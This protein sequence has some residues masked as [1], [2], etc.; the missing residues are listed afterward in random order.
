M[1]HVRANNRQT[2]A[3]SI[4]AMLVAIALGMGLA[5]RVVRPVMRLSA[6]AKAIGAGDWTAT[7][8]VDRDDEVG[9]LSRSFNVMT[10]RIRQLIDNLKAEVAMR[11]R[12]EAG[13]TSALAQAQDEQEKT[14]AILASVGDGI[15]IQS[16][17]YRVLYQNQTHKDFIGDHA[18]EFCYAGYEKRDS[19]C[20]GC[21]VAI[22]FQDG[23]IHRAE[24]VVAFPEGNRYFEITASPLRDST[25][26]IIAGIELVR[27]VTERARANEAIAAEK[28]R[29]AVTLRSIGDAV[30]V[31]DLSGNVTLVNRLAETIT[32]WNAAEAVGRPLAD[33]FTIVDKRTREVLEN[34]VNEVFRSGQLV[35]LR[36]GTALVRRDGSEV[37]IEDSAAPI[38]DA[39][40]RIIGVV[41]VFRDI[42]DKKR[43]EEE[44]LKS[45]KLESLGILAGGLAHDFNNLL[46]AI[47]GNISIAKIHL[48]PEHKIYSRLEDAE[49]AA[50]RA[51]D[52]T[53]RLLTFSKGGHPGQEDRIHRRDHQ[54]VGRFHPLG[55]QRQGG[56]RPSRDLLA[57]GRRFRPDEPGLHQ[58]LGQR[59][60]GDAERRDPRGAHRE[61]HPGGAGS[62]AAPRGRVRENHGE[63]Q[64]Q[65][66]SRGL[67]AEDLRPLFHDKTAGQR[68]WPLDRVLGRDQARGSHPGHLEAG[69]G[70]GI[71]HLPAGVA[72]RSARTRGRGRGP[73]PRQG[74]GS[75]DGRRGDDQGD[76][77]PDTPGTG[78]RGRM[79]ERRGGGD[80]KISRPPAPPGNRSTSS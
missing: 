42:T 4:L 2:V 80:R 56:V 40:S 35:T 24:R 46:T 74:A 28:E 52:L 75:R 9:E 30:I 58:P 45:E 25:G 14:K 15:S 39:K 49:N 10:S 64:R 26:A 17:D 72:G 19:L 78:V 7:A 62:R 6:T 47:M 13:L 5:N 69:R 61:P 53:R 29:L 27:D 63:R 36:D 11:A 73:R 20:E 71:P 22:A 44:L 23:D 12:A 51:T 32:G 43:M 31:T 41:L 70:H 3:L 68:A 65:R 79:R 8:A 54:G 21:P 16:T 57:R 48:P 66:H 18:G 50:F 38:R 1:E 34:P 76:R 67:P 77:R 33:I 59:D 60:P 37:L 55:L